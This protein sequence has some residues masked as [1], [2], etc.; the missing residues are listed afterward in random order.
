M[1]L[2]HSTL[3]E[4]TRKFYNF[5]ILKRLG[6]GLSYR[7][8]NTSVL[9]NLPGIFITQVAAG[10]YHTLA[11]SDRG[12]VC[13]YLYKNFFL[14][15]YMFFKLFIWGYTIINDREVSSPLRVDLSTILPKGESISQILAGWE[16]SYFITSSN[17]LYS[18]GAG[19]WSTL[20]DGTKNSRLMPQLVSPQ[21]YG[22]KKLKT[23]H[24]SQFCILLTTD[25]LLYT[26]GDNSYGQHGNGQ[27]DQIG[28][29][30][31]QAANYTRVSLV[32]G[33]SIGSVEMIQSKA[34]SVLL[35]TSDEKLFAFGDNRY[36]RCFFLFKI[37]LTALGSIG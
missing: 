37:F 1:T 8:L 10:T 3:Q 23:L 26:F 30:G 36:V 25:N 16:T 24:C 2:I 5:F 7:R 13:I 31:L 19:D 15:T 20:G 27:V 21:Y 29:T 18:W 11:M 14:F 34:Q 35:K 28:S 12:E 6:D 9:V 32:K 33:T 22:N 4:F 17:S